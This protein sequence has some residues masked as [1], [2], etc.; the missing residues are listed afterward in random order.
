MDAPSPDLD[1]PSTR[2]AGGVWPLLIL[3]LLIVGG[4]NLLAIMVAAEVA[5]PKHRPLL[6]IFLGT[7]YGQATIAAVWAA[8][9]PGPVRWRYLG[10]IV[11][12]VLMIAAWAAGL[13]A[14]FVSNSF[15]V[16]GWDSEWWL[17]VGSV[18][19]Q[20][21]LGQIPLWT[22]GWLSNQR[23][24]RADEQA[25]LPTLLKP[26]Y[27]I[28]ELMLLTAAVAVVLGI[29]RLLLP[30]LTST[31]SQGNL[32][33]VPIFAFVV[34]VNLVLTLP[35]FLG[36]LLRRGAILGT[37]VALGFVAIATWLELSLMFAMFGNAGA[38]VT[39]MFCIMNG[40]Q[41]A[42]ALAAAGLLRAAGFQLTNEGR[43]QNSAKLA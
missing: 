12:M 8:L 24:A 39:L 26:Q 28:R 5:N 41:A 34:F 18:L 1:L 38:D 14:L 36:V 20:W 32:R 25:G 13:A 16:S 42:W 40:V 15:R 30:W 10:S 7:M 11:W 3:G 27:G 2:A 6:A 43:A 23:I 19:G 21:M 17:V 37:L 33:E 35:V 4:W 31:F 29:G 9:G 22:L